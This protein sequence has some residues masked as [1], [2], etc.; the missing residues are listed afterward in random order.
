MGKVLYMS[1]L[2]K[3]EELDPK[4]VS[5]VGFDVAQEGRL[6]VSGAKGSDPIDTID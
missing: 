1:W 3:R 4:Q 6:Y 2:P 5:A